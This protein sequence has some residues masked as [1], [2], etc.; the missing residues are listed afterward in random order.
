[1]AS[2]LLLFVGTFIFAVSALAFFKPKYV[3]FL[4]LVSRPIIDHFG[5][6]K[7]ISLPFLGTNA[8][9]AIGV[10][11]PF[12]LILS[13]FLKKLD[14]A[15]RDIFFFRER[16]ANYYLLFVLACIP[17][18]LVS[19]QPVLHLGDWLKFL[20]L[21]AIFVFAHNFLETE[22]DFRQA[23]F[24]VIIGSL[25][26]L[27]MFLIDF[28]T[29]NTVRIGGLL[30]ILGGYYQE[31]NIFAADLLTCFVPAYLYYLVVIRRTLVTWLIGLGFVFLIVCIA[32]T[33]FRTSIA[34]ALIMCLCFLLFRKKYTAVLTMVAVTVCAFLVMPELREKFYPALAAL[35][36]IGDLMSTR[37]TISD[38][39]ISTRFG[40]FRTL[41]T[42]VLHRF[43]VG[44]FITGYGYALPLKSFWVDSAHMEFLQ[45]FFRYG[46]LPA[47]LFY[48]FLLATLRRG[49]RC[50]EDEL[51]QVIMAF[52][53]GLTFVSLMGNPFSNVRVLWYLGV[54]VAI[55]S[56]RSCAERASC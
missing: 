10:F 18:L 9:Q 4:L 48:W 8:I 24:W 42:T 21:W 15:H 37:P 22:E 39:L 1:M 43:S 16:L 50:R 49:F 35:L 56:K 5:S 32:A 14:V 29:G 36:N 23:M 3:F 51:C 11:L 30:R 17:A 34:A 13:C 47:L 28:V 6:L 27:G 25:Y 41:I 38:P 2:L 7:E 26:P 46:V 55:L 53:V 52:I 45:L 54:Y 40:I 20:T 44:N 31:K 33:N 12:I 19:A